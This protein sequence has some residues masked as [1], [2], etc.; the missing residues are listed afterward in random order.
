MALRC[1]EGTVLKVTSKNKIPQKLTKF[2][3]SNKQSAVMP[4]VQLTLTVNTLSPIF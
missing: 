1:V 2:Q 4:S 3:Y